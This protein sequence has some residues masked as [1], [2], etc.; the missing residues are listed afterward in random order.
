[1]RLKATIASLR[2]QRQLID[3]AILSL[4]KLEE[5]RETSFEQPPVCILKKRGRPPGSRNNLKAV[6]VAV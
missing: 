1:M 4:E 6:E 3:E 2:I 5:G